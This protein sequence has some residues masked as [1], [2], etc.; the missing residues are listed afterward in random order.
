V[1]R[2][3]AEEFLRR[4]SGR[5]LAELPGWKSDAWEQFFEHGYAN[6]Y[7]EKQSWFGEYGVTLQADC[8][9]RRMMFGIQRD[10]NKTVAEWPLSG[11][12]LDAVRP[13]FASV[14]AKQWWDVQ[15]PMR[16]PASDWT[17]PEALWRMHADQSVLDMVADQML[18]VAK[19]TE[20][21]IDRITE[22]K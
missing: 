12:L 1:R 9:G 7:V 20:S 11:E 22:K 5:L 16:N 21:I 19:T 13:V 10:N 17:T 18:I 3:I 2:R 4:L 8:N 6:F 15:M 14:K